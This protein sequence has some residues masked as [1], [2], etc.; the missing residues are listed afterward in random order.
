[1]QQNAGSQAREPT[2]QWS[3]QKYL[4]S[5]AYEEYDFSA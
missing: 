5:F 4:P 3:K 1:M 2:D